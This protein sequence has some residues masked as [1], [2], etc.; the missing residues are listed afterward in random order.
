MFK[1]NLKIALRNL[2]KNKSYAF[3][4]IAGLAVALTIFILA[5]LYANYQRSYDTWNKGFQQIYRVNYTSTEGEDVALSPGNL[6][7]ISKEN[8]PAIEATTRIQDY[9]FGE[10]LVKAKGKSL[11]MKNVLLADSNFFKV[12]QY[13]AVFGET[14]KSL[15]TPQSV[16]L[17]KEYSDVLFG[18]DVNPVGETITLDNNKGYLIE[19]VIDVARYPSHFKFNLIR[20]FKKS[21]SA[22]FYSNNYYTYV[23]LLN[24]ANLG[25]TTISLNKT[26]KEILSAEL[27]KLPAEEQTGFSELIKNN[28]LY[29]QP[30][31]DIH[32]TQSKVDRK[33]VV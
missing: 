21:A 23:K 28:T 2:W 15:N 5:M 1:L 4:S 8:I 18:K 7:T 13:Q 29:L 11:Y 6:A 30:I 25:Q 14:S 26:R 16:I 3:I 20:R 32:I 24:N 27:R 17:S 22:D 10:M 33:S 12:F 9:W 31:K 19:A